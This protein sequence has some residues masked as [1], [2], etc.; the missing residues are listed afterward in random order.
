[1][2]LAS[3]RENR[4]RHKGDTQAILSGFFQPQHKDTNMGIP[5]IDLKTQYARIQDQVNQNIQNVLE[6]GRYI[7]GPEIQEFETQ[8]AAFAGTRH[9]LSCGSGTDALLLALM[10]LN[11]GPGD[12]VLTTPFTFMATAE[13]I[14]F[15]GAT[16]V[17]VDIDPVTYNL[18]PDK[19]ETALTDIKMARPDLKVKAIMP[20]DLFGLPAEYDRI[21][22]IAKAH[23]LK[24]VVDAAQ[25]FGAKYKGT[26][27]AALGDIA[28]TSFFPAKPLGCYGDGG[29]CFTDSDELQDIMHS[30]RVHGQGSD[31]YDNV[32]IGLNA[33]MDTLQAAVLLPK[34]AIFE[35]EIDMR[36][37]V[38]RRYNEKLADSGLVLPLLPEDMLCV[39][40]QYS[41]QAKDSA[42]RTA[43]Q[44]QLKQQGVPSAIYYPRPLHLQTAFADLG[45][46]PGDLPVSESVGER[47]FALPMSPYL[48]EA[49]QDTVCAALQG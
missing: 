39:W 45:Y 13:T 24:V 23:Q 2:S 17:F 33:R 7:M 28:C 37:K 41:V 44:D 46:K 31:K 43:L 6:H 14:A 49:D 22:E 18:D 30:L 34:L 9:A 10:A 25:S 27:T 48:S 36:Q 5:F 3:A 12:A 47:I 35:E 20:V 11:I 26:C 8:A 42:H 40:A 16:P 38:A 4:Y 29:A 15:L 1:L 21:L 32:R 19:L